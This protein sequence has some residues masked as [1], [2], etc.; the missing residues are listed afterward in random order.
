VGSNAGVSYRGTPEFSGDDT[1]TVTADDGGF[2]GAGGAVTTVKATTIAVIAGND[3]PRLANPVPDLTVME[4]AA[5]NLIELFPGVFADVDSDRLEVTVTGNTNLTQPGADSPVVA[6]VNGTRL[7]LH[8][9]PNGNGQAEIKVTAWDSVEPRSANS[10]TDTFT[11]TITPVNDPPFVAQ[12]IADM[13][14][15][16]GTTTRVVDLGGVFSD[17]DIGNG[18]VLTFS[19]NDAQDNSNRSLLTGALAGSALTLTFQPNRA[20]RADLRVHA[21][22]RS[23]TRVSD[24]F[25]VRVSTHPVA[26]D[27]VATAP[28]DT[29]VPIPVVGNDSEIDGTLDPQTVR[30]VTGQTQPDQS[31]RLAHGVA[32]VDAISGVVTYTPDPNFTGSDSFRYTVQDLDKFTSNEATV[33]VTVTAVPDYQNPIGTQHSDVNKSGGVSPVDALIVINYIN[34]GYPDLGIPPNSGQL[35]PDPVFPAQ[36]PYYWDVD[37]NGLVTAA[38]VLAVISDLN[39][40]QPPPL[41]EGEAAPV[42]P[43]ALAPAVDGGAATLWAVPDYSLL[44]PLPSDQAV[45]VQR[46][47]AVLPA[48][49][50]AAN[51]AVTQPVAGHPVA[52]SPAASIFDALG[53]DGSRVT[54]PSLEDLL[55]E[56][57]ADVDGASGDATLEDRVLSGLASATRR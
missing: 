1:L 3:P 28:E 12:P 18:D 41:G 29:P 13:T 34:N 31:V 15:L 9:L 52:A 30:I 55:A 2:T 8:Y 7:T 47:P 17:P 46:L 35:P 23:G 38:D 24:S 16:I 27:D 49:A 51:M 43:R 53:Q 57:A 26:K 36:P 5:D 11:V 54:D 44:A 20:G 39:S 50:P 22:D 42:T 10:I 32:R 14:V 25:L 4:D 48:E 40:Q 45:R 37:G 56:I 33:T 6:T 19:Y 21:S